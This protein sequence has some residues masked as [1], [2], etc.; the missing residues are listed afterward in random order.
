MTR[1]TNKTTDHS[2]HS[3]R[4]ESLSWQ[5]IITAPDTQFGCIEVDHHPVQQVRETSELI[6]LISLCSRKRIFHTQVRQANRS[7]WFRA[8]CYFLRS[9]SRSVT[10]VTSPV[11]PPIPYTQPAR[12]LGLLAPPTMTRPQCLPRHHRRPPTGWPAHRPT[13][14]ERWGGEGRALLRRARARSKERDGSHIDGGLLIWGPIVCTKGEL[15]SM[16]RCE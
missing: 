11:Q 3:T 5:F 1:F 15:D 10:L 6:R 7:R 9:A 4:D 12:Q 8:Y 14:Q 16:D 2:V 13:Q